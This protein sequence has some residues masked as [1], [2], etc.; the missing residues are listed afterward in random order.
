M[1]LSIT[2][3]LTGPG[4]VVMKK[5]IISIL[6]L[7]AFAWTPVVS[8]EQSP[9]SVVTCGSFII[10]YLVSNTAISGSVNVDECA[11]SSPCNPCIESLESQGCKV[12]DTKLD[13]LTLKTGNEQE[14]PWMGMTYL[15][16][17]TTP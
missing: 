13:H 9:E 3:R 17:C 11:Y 12:I 7:F 5:I 2:V 1:C 8:A 15:L 14:Q 4:R 6:V 16:S 10:E